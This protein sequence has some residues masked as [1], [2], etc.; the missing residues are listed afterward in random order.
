MVI[1]HLWIFTV[2]ATSSGRVARFKSRFTAR[3]DQYDSSDLDFQE[4][5]S[6]V[7][8]WEGVRTYL[9]LTVLLGLIPLQL[10]I[11]LAY[12]YADLEQPVY[13][14]PP[15][16][17][18]CPKGHVWKLKK[19][20]YGLPQSGRNWHKLISSIL[21][22]SDFDLTSLAN[23]TCLFIKCKADGSIILLCLYVDDIY[24]ATS[25]LEQQKMIVLKLQLIFK[26]KILGV[27]DQ[28]L[29]LTLSWGENFSSVHI[30]VGK[31]IRK[32]MRFL[33]IYESN[34]VI[35]PMDPSKKLSKLDCP[36][37][38]E[39]DQNHKAWK[40][41]TKRFQK[42][43]GTAI[44]CM[45][46]CRPDIAFAVG[47]LTRQMHNPGETYMEAALHLVHYL[48]G[49]VELGIVF[50]A[51]G[52]RRPLVYCDSDRGGDE[53]RKSTAGHILF[54]A[55]GPLAWKSSLVD[56]Y[57]LSTCEAEVRAVHAAKPAAMT[58]LYIQHLL[59]E[60]LSH[61]PPVD[62]D[63]TEIE[64]NMSTY[65]DSIL[66]VNLIDKHEPFTNAEKAQLV[67]L[68]DNKAAIDW[69]KKPGAG[70]RMKHLETELH[71]IKRAVRDRAIRLQYVPTKEQLADI[72]TKAL[73]P[74][75]FIALISN[76]M[77]YFKI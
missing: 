52:N 25:S 24:L 34:G 31:A 58:A 40:K 18:G 8:S 63:P 33:E 53:T 50:R 69:A 29:G 2:K 6:P 59:E 60:I 64:M 32:L 20:L 26:L 74:A 4:I 21:E 15:E 47:V 45:N 30:H 44:F 67:I 56:D 9:A 3:G 76:F 68:E 1:P 17:S 71:W 66:Q 16:G 55:G 39:I 43:C 13:I 62:I 7:V 77:F 12:L 27:P 51:T 5:F 42:I 41:F 72:L 70:S 57:P 46:V 23:D 28:L 48:A 54:L 49:T 22:D 37:Q 10:D 14:K 36:T 65:F 75:L 19:S 61:L 73:G 38:E 11:D 35:I